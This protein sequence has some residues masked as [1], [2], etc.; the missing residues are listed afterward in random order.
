MVADKELESTLDALVPFLRSDFQGPQ[1]I[2]EINR[3]HQTADQQL[4]KVRRFA[5]TPAEM[6][7]VDA[8]AESWQRYKEQWSKFPGQSP[9][10]ARGEFA[11]R[12][13]MQLSEE[14]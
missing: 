9:D 7:R 11:S 8:I 1:F 5:N 13:A 6:E 2:D 4:E 14:V 12:L 3:R 10:R